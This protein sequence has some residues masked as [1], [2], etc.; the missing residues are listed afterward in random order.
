[1]PVVGITGFGAYVPRRRLCRKTVAEGHAWLAPQLAANAKGERTIA[2]WDEDPVTMA[3]EACRACVAPAAR[4]RVTA[5]HFASTTPVYLDR[6]NAGL[7]AAAL[8]LEESVFATDV[9]GSRRVG[10]SALLQALAGGARQGDTLV[11][12]GEKRKARAA[13]VDELR[14]GDGAAAI[15]VGA[16]NIVAH[17]LAHQTTTVDFV[18][19]FRAPGES[20]DYHWEE[21]WVRDEGYG[22]IALKALTDFLTR[23][24]VKAV[25]IDKIIFPCPMK[26]LAAD[27]VRRAGLP[28]ERVLDNFS[29]QCGDLGAVNALFQLAA[30]LETSKPREN[31]LV[32]DF[33]QGCEIF[34]L[35]TTAAIADYRPQRRFSEQLADGWTERNYLRYLTTR[36]LIDWD[37]G[38]KAEKD[39]RS[40]LSVLYRNRRAILGFVGA[41][42]C[43]TGE[44]Q[45]P[46]TRIARGD[47]NDSRDAFEPYG[48]AD[49]VGT[50][51]SWSADRMALTPDPPNYYGMITFPEGG[52]LMMDFAD[53]LS[54][55][56]KPGRRMRMVFRIKEVDAPRDY[57]RYFW[58]ATPDSERD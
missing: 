3:L 5:L 47:D 6:L 55:E 9:T 30:H 4:H 1:M 23:P 8:G 28:G 10:S 32:L 38:P 11:V 37:K 36:D 20:Y 53:V 35:Q 2:G 34:L 58:K 52:R 40:S 46:P 48:F 31:I 15:S 33:G 16:T 41:R 57:T 44:V 21:R 42:N 14:C 13:S 51:L 24:E 27:I 50:V 18:D 43:E 26:D 22:G 39:T 54:D 19:R 17:L 49:K 29:L 45:F 25:E 7:V 56:I 12:A